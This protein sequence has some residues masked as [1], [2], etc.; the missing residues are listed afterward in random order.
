MSGLPEQY[1]FETDEGNAVL[2]SVPAD[3]DASLITVHLLAADGQSATVKVSDRAT[4]FKVTGMFLGEGAK[5]KV[6]TS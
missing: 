2:I 4:A 1:S 5:P 3:A 6:P